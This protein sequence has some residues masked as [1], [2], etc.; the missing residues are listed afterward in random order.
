VTASKLS[1]GV[2]ITNYKTVRCL[3]TTQG[4]GDLAQ[5]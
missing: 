5:W 3:E 2:T 4:V 1:Q